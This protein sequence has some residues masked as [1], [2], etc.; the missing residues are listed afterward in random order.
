ME[1]QVRDHIIQLYSIFEFDANYAQEYGIYGS[2]DENEL[3]TTMQEEEAVI[4]KK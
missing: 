4:L 1:T 2:D 3:A